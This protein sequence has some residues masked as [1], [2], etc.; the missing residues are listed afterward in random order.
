MHAARYALAVAECYVRASASLELA[1]AL[2]AQLLLRQLSPCCNVWICSDASAA[3]GSCAFG[4]AGFPCLPCTLAHT[5]QPCSFHSTLQQTEPKERP[6]AP[7]VVSQLKLIRRR[8]LRAPDTA[9]LMHA[10]DSGSVAGTLGSASGG[11][12]GANGKPAGGDKQASCG[13]GSKE[14]SAAAK[15]A[16]ADQLGQDGSLEQADS[17]ALSKE[18]TL[19]QAD[20]LALSKGASGG[21]G[22]L[23]LS[24]GASSTLPLIKPDASS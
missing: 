2:V 9:R 3:M 19:E 16:E 22:S 13:S 6:T 12:G 11:G 17:L 20:S 14:D 23:P 1:A 5:A 4:A 7:Q 24:Q 10:A 21:S 18:G 15:P 8:M